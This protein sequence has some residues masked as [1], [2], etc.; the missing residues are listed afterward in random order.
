MHIGSYNDE[1]RTIAKM[2]KYAR[3]NGYQIATDDTRRHHEIYM[4]DPRKVPVERL[5]T[6]LRLPIC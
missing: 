1:N 5:K 2:E 6:V 4:S 3:E